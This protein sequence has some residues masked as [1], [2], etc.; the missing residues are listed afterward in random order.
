M[1]WQACHSK[2]LREYGAAEKTDGAIYRTIP[3]Y[4]KPASLEWLALS[5]V[6]DLMNRFASRQVGRDKQ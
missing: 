1:G 4:C 5:I 2:R 6:L 3:E